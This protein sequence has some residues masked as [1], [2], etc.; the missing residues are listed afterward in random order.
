MIDIKS[1][2]MTILSNSWA[3]HLAG[4]AGNDDANKNMR[5]FMETLTPSKITTKQ[6]NAL[7][8]K[9]DATVLLVGPKNLV[10]QTHSWTKFGRT[11][12]RP[13]ITTTCLVGSGPRAMPV[14]IDEN[15]AVAL[16]TIAIPFATEISAC[17]SVDDFVKLTTTMIISGNNA[18]QQGC[19]PHQPRQGQQHPQVA[20][21]HQPMPPPQHQE[22]MPPPPILKEGPPAKA[23]EEVGQRK[24]QVTKRLPLP[25]RETHQ[26]QLPPHPQQDE[27]AAKLHQGPGQQQQ[28]TS[29][30]G[31][32]ERL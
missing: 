10:Q 21:R 4:I 29:G 31:T 2:T 26:N 23:R 25:T 24:Q 6:H 16:Q 13:T 3:Q 27:E 30:Q 28:K 22:P 11:Q 15:Q 9:V 32:Q 12:S 7:V 1:K 5:A 14:T 20:T 18:P 8:E 17:K 19:P